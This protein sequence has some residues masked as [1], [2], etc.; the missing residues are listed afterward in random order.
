VPRATIGANPSVS[1]ARGACILIVEDNPEVSEF[2]TDALTAMGYNAILATNGTAALEKLAA[3][4]TNFDVVF[5]HVV[6]PG[7]SG[8]ELGHEIKRLHPDMPVILTGENSSVLAESRTHGF[9]LRH[10][11][12][13][14]ND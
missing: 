12:Y 5:S 3:D 11:P 1:L 13:S 9:K 7:M 10:K 6:M 14:V 8:V 2:A 4:D